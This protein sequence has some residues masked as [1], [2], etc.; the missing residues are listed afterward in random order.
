MSDAPILT[1]ADA[2]ALLGVT[3]HWLRR[4]RCPRLRVSHKV[5]R[6]DRAAV[7]AWIRAY[8]DQQAA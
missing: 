3:E 6:Y 7:L 4:S 2:A 5:V 1:L 8:S